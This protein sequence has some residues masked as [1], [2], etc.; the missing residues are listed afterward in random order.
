MF[1]PELEPRTHFSASGQNSS[2]DS[3]VDIDLDRFAALSHVFSGTCSRLQSLA[4]HI[5]WRSSSSV[6]AFVSTFYGDYLLKRYADTRHFIRAKQYE[7]TNL[8]SLVQKMR[9]NDFRWLSLAE[10]K[11]VP[12]QEMEKRRNLVQELVTWIFDGYLVPLLK[13][14]FM[15][16]RG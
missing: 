8:H 6:S 7:P 14:T 4:A 10:S 3:M 13:V 11:R 16:S 1:V 5:T 9:I 12:P 2:T 15:S